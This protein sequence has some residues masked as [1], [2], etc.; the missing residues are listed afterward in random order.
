M[1]KNFF[2][3]V[4][5]MISIS[6]FL[7]AQEIIKGTKNTASLKKGSTSLP[8]VRFKTG[9]MIMMKNTDEGMNF[10]MLKNGKTI[11]MLEPCV[12]CV[13][14][15]TSEFDIDGDG[16]TEV[17]IGSRLTAETFEVKIYKKAEFEVEYKLFATING[18]D[19]CEFS[20]DN[21]VKIFTIDLKVA[22]LKFKSD[23]SWIVLEQ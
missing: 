3:L 7:K 19:H 17:L 23:G 22:H 2:C 14:G 11:P 13:F 1:K 18:Q 21:T 12:D 15:Q 10:D 9:E 20:G 6:S 5:L 4:V 16:K 8:Q